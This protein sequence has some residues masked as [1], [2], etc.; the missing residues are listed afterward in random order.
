VLIVGF[1]LAFF[2]FGHTWQRWQLW[3]LLPLFAG[4]LIAYTV[5]TGTRHVEQARPLA[6]RLAQRLILITTTFIALAGGL[7]TLGWLR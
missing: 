1:M 5:V 3:A 6:R 7:I 4:G 2:Q